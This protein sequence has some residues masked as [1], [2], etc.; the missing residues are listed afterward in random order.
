MLNILPK[1]SHARKKPPPPP[2][3]PLSSLALPASEWPV[4]CEHSRESGKV[5]KGVPHQLQQKDL[6]LI[7]FGSP[8]SSKIVVYGH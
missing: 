8:F 3:P 1:S 7:R 4:H 6:G 5:Y 2:P